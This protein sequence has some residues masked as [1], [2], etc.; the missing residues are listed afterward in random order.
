M[1]NTTFMRLLLASTAFTVAAPVVAQAQEQLDYT[2]EVFQLDEI[3]VS[4]SRNEQSVLDVPRSVTVISS[5]AVE[6]SLGRGQDIN[7]VLA[8]LV[9]GMG[10][11]NRNLN[12]KGQ[13]NIRGRRALLLIDGVPQNNGF[14]DFGMELSAIDPHN[15]ERIEVIRGGSAIYGL[16]AQ[17]GI[18]NVLTRRPQAGETR[19]RST[20]GMSLQGES[21]ES[22]SWKLNQQAEGGNDQLQWRLGAGFEKR[23]GSFDAGGKR[24]PSINTADYM[25][26]L[27][28][29]G[30]VNYDLDASRSVRFGFGYRQIKD[31]DGWCATGAD[32][33]NGVTA[34]AVHCGAGVNAVIGEVDALGNTAVPNN[35]VRKFANAQIGYRDESFA[36]GTLELTGYW[37]GV[38]TETYTF[39]M[40]DRNPGSPTVGGIVFGNNE[41]DF[42]RTGIRSGITST[43]GWADVTWG[44]D[45]EQATFSQ[46]NTIGFVNVT[47]DVKRNITA[48]Y[49]QFRSELSAKTAL[50]Y[51][52]RYEYAELKV[53]DFTVGN[54]F[55]NAGKQVAGGT[56]SFSEALLNFGVTHYLTDNHQIFASF[57]EGISTNEVLRDIRAGNTDTISGGLRPVKT[58]NY[59]IGIR[60]AR[61]SWDYSLAAFYNESD[62]GATLS[63][64]DDGSFL[65]SERAPESV[66][67][68]ELTFGYDISPVL[69]ASG[70]LSWQEGERKLAGSSSWQPLDGSRIA[71]LKAVMNLTYDAANWGV[72][73]LGVIHSGSRD[74]GDEITSGA[75]HPVESFTVVNAGGKW[76]LGNG[77]LSVGVENLFDT[78]YIPPYVQSAQSSSRYF[79]APGRRVFASYVL[80]F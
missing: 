35:V 59:E 65:I 63:P 17:G 41:T 8:T 15:I 12:S 30:A 66:W 61:D 74:K 57:A 14:L 13:N 64:S 18:I 46:P 45:Y 37:M 68:A 51:G 26:N 3:I 9:P 29:N 1:K 55:P 33:A 19:Y 20:V 70:L 6:D 48:A 52:L 47:P 5:E 32:P 36:L 49:A 38:D 40:R 80:D 10:T 69:R 23:G 16:G 44:F 79:G 28:L 31:N 75:R 7:D 2:G 53:D 27:T 34:D 11:S 58:D 72:Y 56:E 71:P 73:S 54:A 4:A 21:S 22:L 50:T 42:D 67:G 25:D 77:Q 43:L 78:D 76:D 24:L 60:G 62:L 39:A